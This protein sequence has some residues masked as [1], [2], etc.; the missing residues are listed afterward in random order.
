MRKH[1]DPP[2][3]DDWKKVV[4]L[5]PSLRILYETTLK[6][7]GPLYALSNLESKGSLYNK[8]MRK[9]GDPPNKDD[10]KKVVALLPSLRI[11]YETTLKLSGPLYVTEHPF[12]ITLASEPERYALFCTLLEVLVFTFTAHSQRQDYALRAGAI[13]R[14]LRLKLKGKSVHSSVQSNGMGIKSQRN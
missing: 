1:G 8:E 13:L 10:W 2:N 9:H 7:S 5:L 11:L 3:K 12:A 4:A 14:K 6:L